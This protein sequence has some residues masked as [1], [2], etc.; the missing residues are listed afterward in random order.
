MRNWGEPEDRRYI[1]IRANHEPGFAWKS[2]YIIFLLQAALAWVVSSS[3]HAAI[4]G[5]RP[6]GTVDAIGAVIVVFG[7]VFEAVAD[8]Q[9]AAFIRNPQNRGRVMERGVWRYSRHPNYFGECCI[10]WG[11]W[12]LAVSTGGWWSVA[13][14]LLMTVLL[15]RVSGVNLLERDIG[16]RRPAYAAYVARTSAFVPRPPRE[17]L[18]QQ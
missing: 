4:M 8:A 17:A 12:L 5:T 11:F 2:V 10:W 13:S 1:A 15:L 18:A 16:E 3:L 6:L 14:P 7:L 9:L